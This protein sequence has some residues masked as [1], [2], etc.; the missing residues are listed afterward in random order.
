[1]D[2]LNNL[3][4]IKDIDFEALSIKINEI[5]FEGQKKS[6]KL[7]KWIIRFCLVIAII[8][9]YYTQRLSNGT[10]I[11]IVG[12]IIAMILTTPSWGIFNQNKLN[13]KEHKAENKIDNLKA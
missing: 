8:V 12:T 10:Y 9:S 5:D 1:M 2:F 6:E 13:W 3:P 11:L 4:F 7:H